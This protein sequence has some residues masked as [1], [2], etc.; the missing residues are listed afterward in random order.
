M[1]INYHYNHISF[2]IRFYCKNESSFQRVNVSLLSHISKMI[3][4][5]EKLSLLIWFTFDH[6]LNI[7]H[8][9]IRKKCLWHKILI[10]FWNIQVIL[11]YEKRFLRQK[12]AWSSLPLHDDF[13]DMIFTNHWS[14]N[15][16]SSRSCSCRGINII[17]FSDNRFFFH[18]CIRESAPMLLH[19]Y[20]RT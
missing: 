16:S 17:V 12:F 18:E 8:F 3:A 1:R 11:Y 15:E 20:T 9:R 14:S 6:I 2:A 7:F 5:K 4:Q 13:I 19:R 10:T